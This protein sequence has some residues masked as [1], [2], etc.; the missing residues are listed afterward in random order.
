MDM[1]RKIL[2]SLVCVLMAVLSVNAKSNSEAPELKLK[3]EVDKEGYVCQPIEYRVC[4]I[5]NT[6]NIQDVRPLREMSVTPQ[7][8]VIR[9]S[10]A[11]QKPEIS[12]TKGS[13]TYKWTVLRSFVIPGKA[14]KYEIAA[15]DFIAF[16][17]VERLV[18]D[19]F[20]GTRRI[21]DYEEIPLSCEKATFK[22]SALPKNTPEN[23]SD[24]VG[25]FSVEGWFPPGAI[26]LES[27]AIV[28]LK[29]EGYGN[30]ENL[31]LPNV[32]R[33]FVNGCSL[34]NIEQNDAI[35]QRNG[36]L[37]SEVTLTCTFIP[38]SD[39]GEIDPVSFIFFNPSTKKFQTVSSKPLK[40][41]SNQVKENKKKQYDAIEI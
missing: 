7:C 1:I 2:F 33:S 34:Q 17:P 21:I 11:N 41:N 29:I 12:E 9:G 4:L 15:G 30:L 18:N 24:G 27:P 13:K 8:Q 36:S 19:F 5:S 28:V 31:K 20:W 16:I 10:V 26:H 35:S 38:H 39:D 32:A 14:G 40:W 23:F 3:V 6:P 25:E 22:V 37:Y